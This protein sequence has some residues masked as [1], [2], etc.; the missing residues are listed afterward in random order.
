MAHA[1]VA[2]DCRHVLVPSAIDCEGR[3][4]A[5]TQALLQK[6]ARRVAHAGKHS[7]ALR[8]YYVGGVAKGGERAIQVLL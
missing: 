8:L 5:H 1:S 7:R 4:G 3:L 2:H 6:M